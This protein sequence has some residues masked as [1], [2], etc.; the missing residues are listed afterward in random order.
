MRYKTRQ[1]NPHGLIFASLHIPMVKGK[2]PERCLLKSK[3][4][5]YMKKVTAYSILP[6]SKS[7]GGEGG[8]LIITDFQEPMQNHLG[9][10]YPPLP[11]KI[12]QLLAEDL[13]E[14]L[15]EETLLGEVKKQKKLKFEEVTLYSDYKVIRQKQE[16][17]SFSV[18]VQNTF[19]Q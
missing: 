3:Q 6:V 19:W 13:N 14:I 2:N 11:K 1:G 10:D 8:F 5:L 15:L 17:T 18:Y 16:R 9:I 12:A 4:Y 7:I